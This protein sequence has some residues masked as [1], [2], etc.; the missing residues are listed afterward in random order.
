NYV[1]AHPELA[2]LLIQERAQF[3]DRKKPTYFEYR[4]ANAERWQN[5]YRAL[6]AQGRIRD[7]PVERISDV[8]GNLL[9]GTMFV[10]YF[11]G[12]RK[13]PAEEAQEIIDNVLHGILS[14]SER[15]GHEGRDR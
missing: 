8:V 12:L 2:E 6:I 9:Y 3:K 15:R 7:V 10:N 11:T 5:H 4:A 14:E 1:V 13:P